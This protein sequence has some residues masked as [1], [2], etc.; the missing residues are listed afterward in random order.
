[1]TSDLLT[2]ESPP[3]VLHRHDRPHHDPNV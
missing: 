2:L 1:M 3:A